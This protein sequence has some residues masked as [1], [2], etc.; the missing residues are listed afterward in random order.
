MGK[1]YKKT[2]CVGWDDNNQGRRKSFKTPAIRHRLKSLR[3]K[4]YKNIGYYRRTV[5]W[6]WE[7]QSIPNLLEG[8]KSSEKSCWH[9]GRLLYESYVYWLGD[10][11]DTEENRLL[12]AKSQIRSW[13]RK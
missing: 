5:C 10:K 8:L 7:Y 1:S 4:G 2:C 11:E 6:D 9:V 3:N 13:K 12:F